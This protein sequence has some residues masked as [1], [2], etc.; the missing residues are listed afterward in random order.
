MIGFSRQNCFS[1][2]PELRQVKFGVDTRGA[3]AYQGMLNA[4][5]AFTQAKGALERAQDTFNKAQTGLADEVNSKDF[6]QH[7]VRIKAGE[8]ISRL[9]EGCGNLDA[10]KWI[11]S[12][13]DQGM[14]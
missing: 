9:K 10:V 7:D 13:I 1:S 14:N 8:V 3:I 4:A 5:T 12:A 6:K 11:Q 2:N